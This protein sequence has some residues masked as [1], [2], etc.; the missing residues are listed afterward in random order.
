M[1]K[2]RGGEKFRSEKG[3]LLPE[4]KIGVLRGKRRREEKSIDLRAKSSTE[5]R[6]SGNPG[7]RKEEG[8]P[9]DPV[10]LGRE[11]EG[12]YRYSQFMN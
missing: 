4:K 6:E 12:C 1:G 3:I 10:R 7:G 5:E 11:G 9:E 2:C 8:V